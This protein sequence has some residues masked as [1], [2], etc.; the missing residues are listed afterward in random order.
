METELSQQHRSLLAKPSKCIIKR[1]VSG[2]VSEHYLHGV[3]FNRGSASG[4]GP[5]RPTGGG[6]R[7]WR[8]KTKT[9][10]TETHSSR[11]T[12][13]ACRVSWASIPGQ[14]LDANQ[15]KKWK[16][17]ISSGTEPCDKQWTY[18]LSCHHAILCACVQIT[19]IMC[20]KQSRSSECP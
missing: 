9:T 4:G 5:K 19:K 3:N 17:A 10:G 16:T 12:V 8:H 2:R 1:R 18:W 7:H 13:Y 15:L 6:Q 11:A 20:P 14:N